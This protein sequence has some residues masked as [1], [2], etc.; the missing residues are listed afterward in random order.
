MD[1]YSDVKDGFSNVINSY[2]VEE[3]VEDVFEPQ[4]PNLQEPQPQEPQPQEPQPQEPQLQEPQLQEPKLQEP[5]L[6]EPKLREPQQPQQ[7]NSFIYT[8][9]RVNKQITR[10][11]ENAEKNKRF[12]KFLKTT[13]M[14]CNVFVTMA[15]ALSFTVPGN[16]KIYLGIIALILSTIALGTFQW[17]EFQ[18]HGAKW[19]KY[20]K[21]SE[22][23]KSEKY[24]FENHAGRYMNSSEDDSKKL[25]VA[26]IENIIQ[27]NNVSGFSRDGDSEKGT[28]MRIQQ[29]FD[30]SSG[31]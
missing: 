5:K 6:Q 2:V 10:F 23:L 1:I 3:P 22:L 13:A 18:I 25:F 11:E 9:I 27:G 28:E 8:N 21:T 14:F 17:E 15:I 26:T 29:I 4:E 12:Y 31:Y 16:L 7:Q 24:L 19:K 30:S 20:R